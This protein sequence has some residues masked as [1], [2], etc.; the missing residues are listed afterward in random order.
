MKTRPVQKKASTKNTQP[1]NLQT[2]NPKY[3]FIY[4]SERSTFERIFK[5][6]L[7]AL[8]LVIIAYF[9]PGHLGTIL[10]TFVVAGMIVFLSMPYPS[11]KGHGILFEEHAELNLNGKKHTIDYQKVTY[12]RLTI[13]KHVGLS[14]LIISDGNPSI[15]FY[16][17]TT[18]SF[19]SK[20]KMYRYST[21]PIRMF[22]KALEGKI[23]Q[24]KVV[25]AKPKAR[26]Q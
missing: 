6:G 18:Q 26:K 19:F 5:M 7:C 20:D 14:C 12:I 1:Q 21:K 15:K 9:V 2:I 11:S 17:C 25:N 24:K 3:E 10:F 16:A 8:V 23:K 22:G 4:I 13:E